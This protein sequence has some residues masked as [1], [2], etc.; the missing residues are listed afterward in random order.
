M[1]KAQ[2]AMNSIAVCAFLLSAAGHFDHEGRRGLE[3]AST[4]S[5]GCGM[6]A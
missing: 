5:T 2:A 4:L 6:A 1:K 3:C